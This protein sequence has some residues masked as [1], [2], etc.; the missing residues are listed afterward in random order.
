MFLCECISTTLAPYV[1]HVGAG[2]IEHV[3]DGGS[4]ILDDS[5]QDLPLGGVLGAVALFRVQPAADGDDHELAVCWNKPKSAPSI[6][7]CHGRHFC[8]AAMQ[9]F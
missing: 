7:L 3:D 1:H 8:F 6:F 2:G 5:V 9:R 4:A